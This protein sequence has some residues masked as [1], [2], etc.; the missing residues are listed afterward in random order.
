MIDKSGGYTSFVI[1]LDKPNNSTMMELL[2]LIKDYLKIIQTDYEQAYNVPLQDTTINGYQI[3]NYIPNVIIPKNQRENK[4]G[5]YTI[6][7]NLQ[8]H[9][10]LCAVGMYPIGICILVQPPLWST[11]CF[12]RSKYPVRPAYN[13]RELLWVHQRDIRKFETQI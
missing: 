13:V 12:V 11:T 4:C 5:S 3:R 8:E 6:L 1:I 2:D 7:E 10:L 9:D